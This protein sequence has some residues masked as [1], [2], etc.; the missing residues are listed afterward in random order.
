M[1]LKIPILKRYKHDEFKKIGVRDGRVDAA[2]LKE[3]AA[4]TSRLIRRGLLL[5]DLRE[6]H[7][8][9]MLSD[10]SLGWVNEVIYEPPGLVTAVVELTETGARK[11]KG[12]L[13]RWVSAGLRRDFNDGAGS[14]LPGPYLDHVAALGRTRPRI[15]GLTDLAT[16]T[17]EPEEGGIGASAVLSL[18][19]QGYPHR[20]T[21]A[22][23]SELTAQPGAASLPGPVAMF[24]EIGLKREDFDHQA[25]D[26]QASQR[27]ARGVRAVMAEDSSLDFGAAF[28]EAKRR[29]IP[30]SE[31]ETVTV[32][33][34]SEQASQPEFGRK[35]FRIM[36]RKGW[37]YPQ[38]VEEVKRSGQVTG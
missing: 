34:F 33:E 38:L 26:A 23:F 36:K 6:T 9:N 20:G 27:V 4:N 30:A 28:R 31:R 12:K 22:V 17:P 3:I 29:T 5:P 24:A 25:S 10:E 2:T 18:P 7:A 15:N 21:I 16:L 8:G 37:T 32:A 1:K 14:I 11:V 35:A 13:L 19:A